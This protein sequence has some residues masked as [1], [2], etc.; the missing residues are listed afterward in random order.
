MAAAKDNLARKQI[1]I[2][3]IMFEDIP[4]WDDLN[5]R[6][7]RPRITRIVAVITQFSVDNSI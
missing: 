4:L 5:K 1:F 7:T 3:A 2:P 6:R